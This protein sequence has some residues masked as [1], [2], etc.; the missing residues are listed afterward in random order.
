MENI[1]WFTV[2]GLTIDIIGTGIVF[3]HGLP[4]K[5]YNKK[6]T[7][8][9]HLDYEA[10]KKKRGIGNWEEGAS[11]KDIE[12]RDKTYRMADLGFVLLIIGFVM[13][14]IGSLIS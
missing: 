13:Q 11:E 14:L 8:Q 9:E 10:F 1:N 2:I 7:K 6:L 4:S 5:A 12:H 3:K